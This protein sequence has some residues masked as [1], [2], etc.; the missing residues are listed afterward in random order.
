MSGD[1]AP[2]D[3]ERCRAAG[4]DG[5]LAKP[6]TPQ[7]LAEAMAALP[8]RSTAALAEAVGQATAKRLEAMFR[9]EAPRAVARLRQLAEAGGPAADIRRLTHDLTSSAALLGA[10]AMAEASAAMGHAVKRDDW[11]EARRQA[12]LLARSL[13]ERLAN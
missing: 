7:A 9:D 4:M 13:A 8:A 12:A 5:H 11:G 1:S 2:A 6:F 3:A 10:G